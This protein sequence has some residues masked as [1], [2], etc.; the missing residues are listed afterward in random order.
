MTEVTMRCSECSQQCPGELM[1]VM[2]EW[3]EKH[4]CPPRHTRHPD[5]D[6]CGYCFLPWPCPVT[7][8]DSR[9]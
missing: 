1:P 2:W 8:Q 4:P 6:L 5:V 3:L 7:A 9:P